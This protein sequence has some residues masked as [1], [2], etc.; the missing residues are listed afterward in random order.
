[1]ILKKPVISVIIPCYNQGQY[2]DEALNSILSQ[3]Y[4]EFECLIINDGSTDN[5]ELIAERWI[6]KDSKYK[7]YKQENKGLSAARNRGIKE[8]SGDF[9]QFLDCDD[10][11]DSKKFSESLK[12]FEHQKNCSA[13]ISN[14][15]MIHGDTNQILRPYCDLTQVN[16]DFETILHEWQYSFSI[17][18]HCALFKREAIA[19]LIFDVSLKSHEDWIF[20]LEFFIRDNKV[21][22]YNEC[23][24]FYRLN[25][26]GLSKMDNLDNYI[27][28]LGKIKSLLDPQKF[29]DFLKSIIAKQYSELGQWK[30]RFNNLKSSEIYISGLFIRKIYRYMSLGRLKGFIFPMLNRMKK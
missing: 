23:H 10:L 16:F 29:E 2:L 27:S 4:H 9:I 13:I 24:A 3:D 28:A 7:Y 25:F 21:F 15:N 5:T 11:I 6:K 22:F 18:I 8:S 26:G 20:W 1:M 19:D 12:I 30:S 14:F 17:P